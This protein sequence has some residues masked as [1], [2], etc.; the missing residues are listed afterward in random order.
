MLGKK[1]GAVLAATAGVVVATAAPAA[2]AVPSTFVTPR[3]GMTCNTGVTG[4]VGNY[5]GYATCYTPAVAKWK[6]Q[7]SCAYGLNPDTVWI[8]TSNADGWK[9]MSPPATCYWGVNDVYVIEG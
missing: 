2:A 3:Y 9:T 6:V 4:S 5:R 8:Y 1:I 7:V